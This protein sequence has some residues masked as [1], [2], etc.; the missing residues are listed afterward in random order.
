LQADSLNLQSSQG[1]TYHLGHV[2]FRDKYGDLAKIG[3]R[4]D[5]RIGFQ[6]MGA[7]APAASQPTSMPESMRLTNPGHPDQ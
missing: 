3:C 4:P 2:A 7:R 5:L 1:G 6:V